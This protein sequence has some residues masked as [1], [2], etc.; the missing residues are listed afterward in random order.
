MDFWSGGKR[1]M[2][3]FV[4]KTGLIAAAMTLP[5]CAVSNLPLAT[6][7]TTNGDLTQGYKVAAGD[8]LRVTVF[9]EPTL[10]GEYEIGVDGELSLPL[11]ASIPAAGVTTGEL[12]GLIAAKLKEGG[13]VLAPRVSAEIILH[14]PF[15]ILGE[16]VKPGE[17][18][19]SGD[20]TL[21][22]AIAKAGGYTPRAEKRAVTLRR[23][24]WASA[25]R[26]K[27]DGTPLKIAPGDTI[28]IQE[29]F[30]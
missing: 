2:L 7:S 24:Q 11:I 23:Q 4:A 6:V 19:Y 3:N 13:Y 16:V 1:S 30:F 21:D 9:D 22:Q 29:A 26:V 28:T 10:T 12:S 20:L 18:S 15:Y 17:Y 5:G 25:K 8:K 27:L 14:R